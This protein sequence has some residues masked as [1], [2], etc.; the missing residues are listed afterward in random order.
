MIPD[1]A[2][3]AQLRATRSAFY[4][5]LMRLGLKYTI[6]EGEVVVVERPDDDLFVVDL[7]TGRV[8]IVHP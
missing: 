1:E 6:Y 3:A 5:T 4:R 8:E 2:Q 7:S